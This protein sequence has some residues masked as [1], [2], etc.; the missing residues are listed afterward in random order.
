MSDVTA[1][2]R[3]RL[4]DD[5]R[6]AGKATQG[7][8]KLW[9]M[10]VYADMIG[11]SNLETATLVADVQSSVPGQ[12]RTWNAVH[13]AHHDPVRVLREVAAKRSIILAH[14]LVP[15]R[16]I[17]GDETGGVGCEKCDDVPRFMLGGSEIH[18]SGG[19]Q[20]LRALAAVYSDHPDYR[21]EWE[22]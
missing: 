10:D 17:W 22:L 16:D 21:Q 4:D 19:C 6:V 9:G 7:V 13:I 12:L 11:D 18:A 15:A 5:E 8:W 20:T 14:V 3:A 1:F 2:L